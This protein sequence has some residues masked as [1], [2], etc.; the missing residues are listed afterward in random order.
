MP[1]G[2]IGALQIVIGGLYGNEDEIGIVNGVYHCNTGCPLQ[3]AHD[4]VDRIG[5][6]LNDFSDRILIDLGSHDDRR[7]RH[8]GRDPIPDCYRKSR[9]VLSWRPYISRP[10]LGAVGK[11]FACVLLDEVGI[12]QADAVAVEC[13]M[14][15]E[16]TDQ[17]R[18]A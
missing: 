2:R 18:L 16:V 17:V 12:D 11:E 14:D 8:A 1:S 4:N 9:N 6:L 3:V 7:L 5:K 13:K 15:G 10:L